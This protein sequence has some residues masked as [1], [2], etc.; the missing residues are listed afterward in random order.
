MISL[1]SFDDPLL[2][3]NNLTSITVSV[4]C[5]WLAHSN[6]RSIPPG[7]L[8]ACGYAFIGFSVLFTAVFRNAEGIAQE[9]VDWAI[10]VTKAA[11][12]VTFLLVIIRQSNRL[13]W[14]ARAV[15]KSNF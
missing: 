8:I 15:R 14:A 5:W 10:V 2:A 12:T 13:R 6:A 7:R 9:P 3:A 4:C 11:L 1:F